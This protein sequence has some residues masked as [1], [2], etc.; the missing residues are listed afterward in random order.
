[1]KRLTIIGLILT[2]IL[3]CIGLSGCK[4]IEEIDNNN[5]TQTEEPQINVYVLEKEYNAILGLAENVYVMLSENEN[6][7]TPMQAIEM[8]DYIQKNRIKPTQEL[9]I[10]LDESLDDLLELFIKYYMTP[11]SEKP[12]VEA[13]I[14]ELLEYM[15][16]LSLEIERIIDEYK[17]II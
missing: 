1:M 4:K 12:V 6:E 13:E 10:A 2:L 15:N 16:N 3:S 8:I 7:M 14:I 17:T 5:N 9:T 11:E